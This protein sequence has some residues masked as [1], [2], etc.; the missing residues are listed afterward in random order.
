VPYYLLIVGGP[1]EIPFHFQYQLDVQYAVGRIHFD[2]LEEYGN[3]A[4]SVVAAEAADAALASQVAFFDPVNPGDELTKNSA[5]KLVAPLH[6][7]L[8]ERFGSPWQIQPPLAGNATKE[9]LKRFM[10]GAD[11]PDLLFAA[12]HGVEFPKE[13]DR[14][15][16]H[17]GALVCQEWPGPGA[18]PSVPPDY[19]FSGD[20]LG[21]EDNLKGMIAFFF[22]CYGAGTPRFD[23]YSKKEF[24]QSAETLTEQPF[25]AALPKRMLSLP[26]GGGAL[27]VIGHVER[28]WGVSFLGDR[29]EEQ[30]AVFQSAVQRL[31]EGVPVGV[32]MEYMNGR[33]AA[34]TTELSAAIERRE[35]FGMPVSDYDL[36][37]MWTASNDA[38]GYI[39]LGDPA[40]RLNVSKEGGQE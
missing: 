31:L 12:C 30:I 26:N 19:Y 7:R 28:A 10:G 25:V 22:A 4:R 33:Y 40:V 34:L 23:E 24:Q 18:E 5:E 27:A 8:Q 20:D 15:V 14:Q 32:A 36:A 21:D 17:Q 38:R 39:V 3:Y 13:D 6:H 9:Q 37:E 29:K 35:T 11:T 1:E 16:R 2:R